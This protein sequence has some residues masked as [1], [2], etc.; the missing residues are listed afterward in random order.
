MSH[1]DRLT[2]LLQALLI[3][4]AFGPSSSL[5]QLVATN[6][7][8]VKDSNCVIIVQTQA[9][10][11]VTINKMTCPQDA[12][13]AYAI[14]YIWLNSLQ[15]SFLLAK[16]SDA[17]LAPILGAHPVVMLNPVYNALDSLYKKYGT[18]YSEL[19]P[20]VF[21]ERFS[22]KGG[23]KTSIPDGEEAIPFKS[24]FTAIPVAVRRS[25]LFSQFESEI[26]WP[27]S[28][29]LDSIRSNTWSSTYRYAYTIPEESTVS[30]LRH[31]ERNARLKRAGL[32]DDVAE[33]MTYYRMIGKEEF[34]GY[35]AQIDD[36]E[37]SLADDKIKPWEI[38]GDESDTNPDTD[39]IQEA[40]K[41]PTYD[42][43]AEIGRDYWPADF[44]V[45]SGTVSSGSDEPGCTVEG[46][47]L[48]SSVDPRTLS[49]LIAV[50]TPVNDK[51]VIRS[52]QVV[53]DERKLLRTSLDFKAAPVSTGLSDLEL[54][55]EN[56]KSLVI[57]LSMEL[58]YES[59]DF[60]LSSI[61]SDEEGR[62]IFNIFQKYPSSPVNFRR[63]EDSG[64]VTASGEPKITCKSFMRHKLGDLPKPQA[65]KVTS[66]YY[67]GPAL[68]LKSLEIDGA[69]VEVRNVPKLSLVADVVGGA[70]SC[71][72][73]YFQMPSGELLYH[74]RVLVGANSMLK[75][76]YD[77]VQ[78]PPGAVKLILKELEPEV[79]FLQSVEF[80][81]SKEAV[82]LVAFSRPAKILPR[83][84]VSF[85]IPAGS[86]E[87]RI[88][89]YYEPLGRVRTPAP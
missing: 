88:N 70:G 15:A 58:R 78:I 61:S 63:C 52:A 37:K 87:V 54:T 64:T 85:D 77:A 81:Q 57:P 4:L 28:N 74:G 42:F 50:V 2:S 12:N 11:D 31:I 25:F 45:L 48:T 5:A 30:F 59:D 55:S 20:Y 7:T 26:I 9:E 69:N 29:F 44:L 82:H 68:Q 86:S 17:N 1:F 46:G 89:G 84:E 56:G 24:S 41:N 79:T 76:A 35:W 66:S 21:P 39:L 65:T 62:A 33:C 72:F 73:A 36:L 47:G 23:I 13:H 27:D 75:S 53:Q 22:L 80:V 10:G 19:S 18:R 51:I 67:F 6:S 34:D 60:P 38:S 40:S 3:L 8:T 32:T 16:Y 49:V 71:P 83:H 43:Y 14:R